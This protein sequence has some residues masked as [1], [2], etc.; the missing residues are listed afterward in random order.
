[1]T[2]GENGI[3]D[4]INAQPVISFPA[5]ETIEGP[6]AFDVANASHLLLPS[7]RTVGGNFWYKAN[8]V[9]D[10]VVIDLHS[11]ET[12]SQFILE[13]GSITYL[14][15]PSLVNAGAQFTLTG[16]ADL[17]ALSVPQLHVVTSLTLSSMTSMSILDLS[18]FNQS[19]L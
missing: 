12:V 11:L 4:F 16:F 9:A 6:F 19:D 10:L 13:K 8:D 18:R 5:L 3:V 2:V 1:M 17:A 14:D 15:L 7:L